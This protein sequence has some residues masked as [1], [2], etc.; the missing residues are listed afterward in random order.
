MNGLAD[1]RRQNDEAARYALTRSRNPAPSLDASLDWLADRAASGSPYAAVLVDELNRL[2]AADVLQAHAQGV[3]DGLREAES[4]LAAARL[5]EEALEE[6]LY[7]LASQH[8]TMDDGTWDSMALSANADAMHLL[9]DMGR[10]VIDDSFARRVIA[11]AA[12]PSFAP[13]PVTGGG[14]EVTK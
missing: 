14:A 13:T 10:I 5:R 11:H 4:Q 2:H 9:A 3:V 12:A 6:A 7:D 8:C 1:I